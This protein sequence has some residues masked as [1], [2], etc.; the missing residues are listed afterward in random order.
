MMDVT[1]PSSFAKPRREGGVKK[2]KK[3]LILLVSCCYVKGMNVTLVQL[4]WKVVSEFG[5]K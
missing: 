3:V 2:S 1:W 5:L 4:V